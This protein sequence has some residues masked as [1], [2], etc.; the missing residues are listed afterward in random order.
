MEF[1]SNITTT[2]LETVASTYTGGSF[3]VTLFWSTIS[4]INVS[5]QSIRRLNSSHPLHLF[6]YVDHDFKGIMIR[7]CRFSI[8]C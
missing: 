4:D 6:L 3:D 5:V 2:V 8:Y 1:D 7:S